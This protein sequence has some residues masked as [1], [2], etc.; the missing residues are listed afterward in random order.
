[1]NFFSTNFKTNIESHKIELENSKYLFLMKAIKPELVVKHLPKL[2]LVQYFC[3]IG[4][5]AAMWFGT[6]I[7]GAL[8]DI[9]CKFKYLLL[10]IHRI[11]FRNR[12]IL[13][14]RYNR[15]IWGRIQLFEWIIKKT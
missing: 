8:T 9:S 2:S 7:S 15:N 10:I 11:L 4:S 13:N 12:N 1:M 14:E 3:S 5:L 6:I